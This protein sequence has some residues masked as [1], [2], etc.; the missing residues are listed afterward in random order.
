MPAYGVNDSFVML[1]IASGVFIRSAT[2]LNL[3]A[4]SSCPF[5]EKAPSE[6][7]GQINVLP[8]YVLALSIR[9]ASV[10]WILVRIEQR[11]QGIANQSV[12]PVQSANG[13]DERDLTQPREVENPQG[14]KLIS[15]IFIHLFNDLRKTSRS[16][17]V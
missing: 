7:A 1:N 2:A 17:L 13:L 8:G 5:L 3:R 11:R 10:N 15:R 6:C 12:S 14:E 16:H 4:C 9:T